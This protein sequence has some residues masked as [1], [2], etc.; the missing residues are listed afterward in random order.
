M[1]LLTNINGKFSVSDAGA[2]TFNNAFTFPTVDGAANYVLQTNGSGQ[3]AWALNGNGDISGSGTANTVTKFTGAKTIGDGPITF[4]GNNSAFIGH[5]A[6]E[7]G[8]NFYG[9]N[10]I[11]ASS[12]DGNYVASFGKST[13]GSAKFAGNITVGAGNSSFAGNVTGVGAS[14]I[15]TAASGAALVT[16]ENNSGSTATSYGLLVIGGGNSSNGRTF[17]VRDASGNTDLIVKGNGNVGIGT[18]SPT[19][20]LHLYVNST[21]DDTFQ[22][23]NGSVRTHLLASES[24]NGVIYMRSSANSNTIRINASGDSYFNGGNVGIGVTSPAS[25]F[26][27]Y[28]GNSGVNDVDRYVRFKASNGEKRFDFYMGGTGNAS[29]LGMYTSDGTTKNVQISAGGTS[30][31]NAGNVGIGTTSPGYKLEINSGTTNVTSAF[32]STDN[33]AWIS[34]QDDDSGTYGA[35]IG[36]DS[37]ESENFVVANVSA[38]KMLSLNSSGSLKLHNYNSTNNTGTPTYVLGTDASGNVVKVLGSDIPGVPAGSGTLKTIPLWTPDGDTLGNSIITQPST[39]NVRVSG[40]SVYFSVTDTSAAARNIDIGHWISGQTNIESEGGTLSIGTQ[41]NHNIVFETNGSTK[42]TILSGGNVGIGTTTPLANLDIGN[43]SGSIYQRWSYD[44]PG[45]NNYFLSLSETVT[46]GNVRFCFNQRNAG[47]NYDNVLVFNQGNVGIGTSSPNQVGYGAS[48][49]VLSLKAN[50]S[51]GESVLELIG[52]GNAD[53]DQVGVVN[54]MSQSDTTPLA[55]IKGLRHTSDSSGKLSFETAAVE[56]MRIDSSG[57]VGIKTTSLGVISGA[58]GTLNLGSTSSSL[59]GGILYQSNGTTVAYH[60]YESSN[61]LYQNAGAY[62]HVFLTSN[63]TERMRIAS[64]G[65]VGIGT[66]SPQSKLDLLQPDSS[67]N[68]LGQSVTAALG[69]RMAN[70]IGQVGQ[71]V[72]NNDAAPSY[73]YGSIGMIMTSGTGVGLGD[74]I[75][76]TKSTGSDS[77]STERMRITSA[78]NV[79]IG[80]TS[81]A[82]KLHVKDGSV[83]ALFVTSTTCGNVGI[84]TTSPNASLVVKGNVSYGYNNYSS[85]A[86]TWSNALNFSGYPAGLYQINICKQSNA[87]AYIIAQIKWSGTA[88]T[89][90]NTV[91]SFQYG[92]TFSGTQLQSIINTTTASSISAQ[93]LVTYELACV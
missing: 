17:E 84:K 83:N 59:S 8:N 62:G 11:A 57:A 60:Y 89:V 46:S 12:E 47:T 1:A 16:I 63:T 55:S 52:L 33:Q 87:S 72:F 86:N 56:R 6:V 79:G 15:G 38:S 2:V 18:T 85:V 10:S 5:I 92:I 22:I 54:F 44:N 45:A 32:K 71:I 28:G 23:F 35:L 42:A 3:L 48:A 29:S 53:N 74:M 40:N 77:A 49:K 51:G 41:S 20:K 50:T 14:F 61:F 27:V 19:A 68:T 90:I 88:G 36:I 58:C 91:T 64:N 26:E 24:S 76:S 75:F 93:C 30:Y 21:N 82:G 78:G 80:E 37:D 66:T 9:A 13:S 73:G 31:F 69:I 81:P 70:A 39:G 25:K 65:N 7:D 43:D 67:A 34:I 4:S